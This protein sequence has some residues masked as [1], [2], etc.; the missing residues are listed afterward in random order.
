VI[1]DGTVI[2]EVTGPQGAVNVNVRFGAVPLVMPVQ[3]DVI[4]PPGTAAAAPA[5]DTTTGTM[6]ADTTMATPAN[7]IRNRDIPASVWSV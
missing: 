2:E 5:P 4:D 3:T 1:E 7:P 6:I